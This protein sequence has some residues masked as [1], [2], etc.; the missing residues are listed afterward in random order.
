MERPNPKADIVAHQS[1]GTLP[2]RYQSRRTCICLSILASVKRHLIEPFA[3]VRALLIALAADEVDL[4]S[5]LP[6]TR[7]KA[8]PEYGVQY[9]RDE[10]EAAAPR[11]A[12]RRLSRRL[13]ASKSSE[14]L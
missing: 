5:L 10:L 11:R 6:D 2:R 4:E 13:K 7:I 8:H 1:S 12:R 14:G 9:R 3:Y